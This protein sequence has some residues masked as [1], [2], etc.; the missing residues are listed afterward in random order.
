MQ[1]HVIQNIFISVV[2][3]LS[4]NPQQKLKLFW[5][6]I[7]HLNKK[8]CKN[9]L[10]IKKITLFR[11]EDLHKSFPDHYGWYFMDRRDILIRE[12]L[13][14]VSQ[15]NILSHELAHAYQFQILKYSPT[16]VRKHDKVGGNMN[17]QFLNEIDKMIRISV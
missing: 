3:S 11:K 17:R 13:S 16:R 2:F 1:S 6:I 9:K 14:L 4:M 5:K 7:N 12:D 10:V 8:F 15:L